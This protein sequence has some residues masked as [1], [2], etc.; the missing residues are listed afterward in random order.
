MAKFQRC[1]GHHAFSVGGDYT[2]LL[3]TSNICGEDSFRPVTV[4]DLPNISVEPQPSRR[5]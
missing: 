3:E 2:V 4:L 5:P 1:G